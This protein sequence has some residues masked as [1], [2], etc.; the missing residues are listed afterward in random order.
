MWIIGLW[1]PFLPLLLA[2][3]ILLNLDHFII[4]A[5]KIL[6]KETFFRFFTRK[7]IFAQIC[8]NRKI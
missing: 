1:E 7:I 6:L 5:V 3:L 8:Q 4:I 2:S